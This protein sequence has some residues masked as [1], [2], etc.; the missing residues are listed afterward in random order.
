MLV[1]NHM[2]AIFSHSSSPD[3]R[4]WTVNVGRQLSNDFELSLSVTNISITNMSS[5]NIALIQL[6]KPVSFSD[7]VQPL[8]V[9]INDD[10]TFPSG[11]ECW[12]TGWLMESRRKRFLK[13][14]P[15]LRDLETQVTACSDA[16]DSENIC[17]F[18][19]DLQQGHEGSPLLCKSESSW[20]QAAVVT[21]S[22][23][24]ALGRVDIQVF[25]K[26]S[27]FASF[28]KETVGDMPSPA[29]ISN[30]I[31]PVFSM[32]LWFIPLMFSLL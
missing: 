18:S 1:F 8:C 7:Y 32:F 28:L 31:T 2:Y 21:L 22:G 27:R 12:V 17:T 11:T 15:L 30:G 13:V 4:E 23:N 26:T 24:K 14:D 16:S 6:T 25:A 20:F 29:S 10:L 19:V 9:D 5:S 3:F